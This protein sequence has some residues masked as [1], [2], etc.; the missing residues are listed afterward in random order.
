MIKTIIVIKKIPEI[1]EKLDFI[2]L[3]KLLFYICV[4]F[5]SKGSVQLTINL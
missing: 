3:I 5:R 1:S 2:T 4:L